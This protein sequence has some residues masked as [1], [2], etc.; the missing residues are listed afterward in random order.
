MIHFAITTQFRNT[1]RIMLTFYDLSKKNCPSC[2]P[3]YL[4]FFC[5]DL[6]KL[7]EIR[8]QLEIIYPALLSISFYL[9]SFRNESVLKMHMH[10]GWG[11]NVHHQT[12]I[13]GHVFRRYFSYCQVKARC[14]QGNSHGG[15][16]S[17]DA[18]TGRH[19]AVHPRTSGGR[20][21]ADEGWR[22]WPP[23]EV[24]ERMASMSWDPAVS[25]LASLRKH[26]EAH[27]GSDSRGGTPYK[28]LV[29][30]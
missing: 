11:K 23:G 16:L 5:F 24:D 21:R 3:E 25:R 2:L 22:P 20:S 4:W 14:H 6:S 18:S 7:C 26:A 15:N 12:S 17:S 1:I 13:K 29:I 9:Y 10:F 28:I 30:I 27:G 19:P 8:K